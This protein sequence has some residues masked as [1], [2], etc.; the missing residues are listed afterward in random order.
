MLPEYPV[1]IQ[2]RT[3]HLPLIQIEDN[4]IAVSGRLILLKK[5]T[6]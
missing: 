1:E 5:G 4:D 6:S 3:I 2:V